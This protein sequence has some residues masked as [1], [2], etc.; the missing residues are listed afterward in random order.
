M[1]THTLSKTVLTI[2]TVLVAGVS[3]FAGEPTSR[4]LTGGEYT[5]RIEGPAVDTAGALYAMNLGSDGVIG[6]LSPGA[7]TSVPFATLPNGGIGSG[8]R[9][10]RRGGCTSPISRT[11]RCTSSSPVKRR[12]VCTSRPVRTMRMASSISQTIWQWR[13]T[14]PFTPAI[15]NGRTAQAG[16]G[17]S[18][19]ERTERFAVSC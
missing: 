3:G 2:L 10:D 14:A 12:L 1:A 6:K 4:L 13:P 17:G 16:S 15:P 7:T 18:R 11:T 8:A 5:K 9:F 19:A